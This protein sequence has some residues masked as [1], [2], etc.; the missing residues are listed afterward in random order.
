M[1]HSKSRVAGAAVSGAAVRF[2]VQGW[3]AAGS[4]SRLSARGRVRTEDTTQRRSNSA[5][6]TVR[7]GKARDRAWSPERKTV[8]LP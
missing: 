6:S 1:F 3:V 4:E 8:L 5:T 2:G 7:S